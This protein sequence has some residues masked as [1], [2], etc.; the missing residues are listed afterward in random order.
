MLDLE[1]NAVTYTLISVLLGLLVLPLFWQSNP[2]I[3]PLI[4]NRQSNA[5]PCGPPPL[6]PSAA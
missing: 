6:P 3:H 4:L 2:D 5:A 1:F